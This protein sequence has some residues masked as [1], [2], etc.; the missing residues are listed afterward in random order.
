[1]AIADDFSVAVNGDIRYTGD[2]A[3]NNYTVLELHRFLQDLADNA[4]V[5]NDDLVDITSD[6]PS[7][8]ATDNIITLNSPYN[9]DDNAAEHLY[10]GSITQDG[11]NTY[12]RGLVVVGALA[13]TTTLQVVQNNA[14][15][16]GDA[17]FWGTGLNAVP[18]ENILM[19]CMIKTRSGGTTI[20]GER[21]RVFAREWGHT[22]AE[23]SVTMGL[24]NSVA[25]I[26]TNTDL[27]NQTPVG[28][29]GGWTTITNVE[30][31]QL[32]DLSNG[33]GDRPY[34]SQW[35]KAT[36]SINQLYERAKYLSRRGTSD[37]IHSIDGE[38]FRG[39]THQWDYDNN[40]T[41][42]VFSTNEILSWGSG[43]TAGTGLLLAILD[44]AGTG[45]MWIQLLTGVAPTDGL[46]ITGDSSGLPTCDVNGTVT[47][48]SL[49]SVFL[50]QSTGSAIIGGFGIGID[51]DDLTVSD[52]LFDLTNAQQQPPN[53]VQF[54]VYGLETG[55]DRVLCTNAYGSG[56]D[57]AQMQLAT[58]LSANPETSLV[59]DYPTGGIPADT[60]QTGV[61][62]VETDSGVYK[63]VAFTAHDSSFT[64][65]INS[66]FSG[67]N[68]SAGNN[69]FIAYID[70]LAAAGS[71]SFTLVY[72][73]D[74]TIFVRVRD[75]GGTPIKTYE[76]TSPLNTGGGSA[77]A[78][79][80]SDA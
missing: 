66:D 12:Y 21:I 57:F 64:F 59:I 65:T 37:T 20:D 62:R 1:M 50:G 19:Q 30:G 67:D 8:R 39:I 28:T 54:T 58:T 10:D 48:R 56:I 27:N 26:F 16:E 69:V 29:V 42:D 44:N 33:N 23:F 36:Y 34:Y 24:G 14:L 52:L 49:P 79:R 70:K 22:F 13:G 41:G 60:P 51:P 4:S 2:S 35:D 17:P 31:Y 7:E 18:A 53:N 25:A 71:E 47:S 6:T 55:Q 32:I 3:Q 80:I 68:A 5:S 46:T 15:Y 77:T 40:A 61:L 72:N 76:T 43:G 9:I 73:N 74:R 38:L 75:G 11:G 63:Y 45:T 78:N